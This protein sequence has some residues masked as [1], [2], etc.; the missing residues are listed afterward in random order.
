MSQ[1]KLWAITSYFDPFASGHRLPVY[2]EFRRRLAVPLVAVELKFGGDFHLQPEEADILIRR[3]GGS[4]LWQ[5]E[6]LLNLALR[7]LPAH[8]EAVAWLDCDVVF[9]REDW[10]EALLQHLQDFE[11]EQPFRRFHYQNRGECLEDFPIPLD[12]AFESA[13]FQFTQGSLPEEAYKM[14]GLSRKLRYMPGAAWAARR[15]LLEAHGVYDTAVLGGGDKLMFSAAAGRYDRIGR[16]MSPAHQSHFSDW[17]KPFANSVKRR[18]SYIEGDL[19][20]LW[21][22]DVGGRRYCERREGFEEFQFDPRQDLALTPDGV[23]RWNNDK[24]GM[25]AFVREQLSRLV[26][27]ATS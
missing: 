4:V 27:P 19:I 12:G 15:E 3:S 10:P 2:R 5:K 20:H 1:S 16:W 6:R 22:G 8:V 21:H 9:L 18:I 26:P 7:A 13:A 11:M 14:P 23:W 25:Q 24:L 17:A